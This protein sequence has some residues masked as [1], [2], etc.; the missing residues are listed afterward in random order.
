MPR[1]M[2]YS[3]TAVPIFAWT[4]DGRPVPELAIPLPG[5]SVG[6]QA[7]VE[8]RAMQ[9]DGTRWV[10]SMWKDFAL[11]RKEDASASPYEQRELVFD[12]IELDDEIDLDR[13]DRERVEDL[14]SAVHAADVDRA[15]DD[16]EL[17][18]ASA[19]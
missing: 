6:D 15:I 7:F 12:L 10:A 14:R 18:R 9:W 2:Q 3:G 16:R 5:E 13:V 4:S 8:G 1:Q 17:R 11:W 19:P